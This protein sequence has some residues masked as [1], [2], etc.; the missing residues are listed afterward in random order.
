VNQI[1]QLVAGGY[2]DAAEM[3]TLRA[4]IA[5]YA[6]WSTTPLDY[7]M[8]CFFQQDDPYDVIFR[9]ELHACRPA[10]GTELHTPGSARQSRPEQPALRH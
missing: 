1:A 3:L 4:A 7:T 9:P 5:D 10:A 8:N 2:N 6:R